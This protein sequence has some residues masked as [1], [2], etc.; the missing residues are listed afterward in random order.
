[1]L[2][3][4]IAD[5]KKGKRPPVLFF[6]GT[7]M[8]QMDQAIEY[9]RE[10]LTNKGWEV[11]SFDLEETSVQQLIMEADSSSLFSEQ[12]MMIGRNANF[13]TSQRSKHAAIHEPEAL[14][15]YLA[16][17]NPD[18]LVVFTV[19]TDKLDK[20]KKVV[21]ELEKK[22]QVYRFDPLKGTQLAQ[23]TFQRFQQYEANIEKKALIRFVDLVGTDLRMLDT[24]CQKVATYAQGS[25]I[26]VEI[27]EELVPRTL[28]QN[29]F[30]LTEHIA[31]QNQAAAIRIWEDLMYQ[32]EEPIKILALITR[33][34]RLL[35]QVKLFSK[36]GWNEKEIAKELRM[37]P[38][39][40]KLA[41][42]QGLRYQESQLKRSLQAAINTESEIKEGKIGRQIGVERLMLQL[43]D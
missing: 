34:I 39:P 25:E 5:W 26:T 28:E 22:A 9:L 21:K 11:T 12:K 40:I 29:V 1:M 42:Q 30:Q 7:E 13:L 20:R 3:D 4:V 36:K 43:F 27:V 14:I 18:Y 41:Y 31:K 15:T 32:K 6:Y 16:D 17:P 23:W 35:L 37:H 38:Y 24:E 19:V 10:E 8:F 2:H 33:Q